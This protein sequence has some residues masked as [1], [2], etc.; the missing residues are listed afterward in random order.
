MYFCKTV[1]GKNMRFERESRELT[2]V[3]ISSMTGMSVAFLHL[4]ESGKRTMSYDNL[5]YL[6]GLYDITPNDLLL[7]RDNSYVPQ[8]NP[9]KRNTM[10]TFN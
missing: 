6:C 10:L 3:D 5:F 2:L 8:D 1:L 4:L 7:P 9:K